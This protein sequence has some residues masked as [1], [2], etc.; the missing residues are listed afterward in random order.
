[1]KI[2][3]P[4]FLIIT[5]SCNTKEDAAEKKL[6]AIFESTFKSNEPGGA[7]LIAKDGK[8]IY[9]KGFGIAE[10][11]TKEKI[12]EHTLFNLG[13]VSK[14]FVAYGILLLARENKLSLDDDLYK[15]FPDFKDSSL[16]KKVKIIHLLTHSSGLPDIRNVTEDSVF[17]L[18][19]KDEENWAPVKQ[20]SSLEFEPGKKF[21][22]SNPAFNGLALIIE[23]VSGTKWQDFVQQNILTPS[24]MKT[25][26]IT[27]GPHPDNGVAHGYLFDGK[28]YLE[29]DY[30]EEPTF[31]ASGNG[32]V[33]SSVEELWNYEQAI[34][35]NLFLDSNWITKSRTPVFFPNWK[36]SLPPE[37]GLS[38][39]IAETENE[40]MI[41]H[42]GSQGGFRSD[43]IWLPGKNIFYVILCN[44]PKPLSQLRKSVL[45]ILAKVE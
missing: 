6:D 38:W 13:S 45:D 18:T 4:V 3:L 23:K 28:K 21:N 1:M 5:I 16:A 30:G 34:Q 24:G 35:K 7:V 43:Y 44:T 29:K 41:G 37:V 14:T 39:F 27:N 32:G 40:K 22:Y 12:T 15:Y 42:T 17:Y 20:A 19:A 11:K 10:T 26:T 31:A 25:S 8:I 33:W 36:D 9:R 2:I